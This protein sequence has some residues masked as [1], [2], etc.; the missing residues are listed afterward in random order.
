[1]GLYVIHFPAGWIGSLRAPPLQGARL[2][3]LIT[4]CTSLEETTAVKLAIVA[5]HSVA[6]SCQDPGSLSTTLSNT[7]TIVLLCCCHKYISHD[8][9]LLKSQL[10]TIPNLSPLLLGLI[11]SSFS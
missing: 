11:I 1:M 2:K 3:D 6:I 5:G 4:C 9:S 7:D 10:H 8:F